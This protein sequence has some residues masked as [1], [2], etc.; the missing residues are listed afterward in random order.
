MRIFSFMDQKYGERRPGTVREKPT[1]S[2]CLAIGFPT[3]VHIYIFEKGFTSWFALRMY[4]MYM[5]CPKLCVVL[6]SGNT[7]RMA[8]SLLSLYWLFSPQDSRICYIRQRSRAAMGI[9]KRFFGKGDNFPHVERRGTQQ[10]HGY[11]VTRALQADW[12]RLSI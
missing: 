9:R 7:R 1:P 11:N 2:C 12:T 5:Y 8:D 6:S 4:H 10:V 3:F